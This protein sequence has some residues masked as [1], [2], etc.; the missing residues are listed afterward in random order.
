MELLDVLL[1]IGSVPLCCV[2]M[3]HP[4]P[5]KDVF[6]DLFTHLG[7]FLLGAQLVCAVLWIIY[8]IGV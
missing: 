7:T 8:K 4:L 3:L 6:K 5:K 1:L 2:A